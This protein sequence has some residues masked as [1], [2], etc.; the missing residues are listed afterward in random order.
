MKKQVSLHILAS[1]LGPLCSPDDEDWA[2]IASIEPSDNVALAELVRERVLPHFNEFDQESQSK[3][4]DS[5]EFFL[6]A[7]DSEIERVFPAFHIPI[8]PPESARNFFSIVWL[9]L[10]DVSAPS[11]VDSSLFVRDN[12]DMFVN[13][14]RK[15]GF[16]E[17]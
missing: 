6:G 9:E 10:F 4:R 2:R 16:S 5:L 13:S 15:K 12:S 14:L 1:L 8:E 17:S 11:A 3:M 7:A